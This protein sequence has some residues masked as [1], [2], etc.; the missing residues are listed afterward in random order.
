MALAASAEEP[1]TLKGHDGWVGGVALSA[2][3]K[4]LATASADNT[5]KL[6]DVDSGKATQVF[7]GHTDYVAA[8]AISPDGRAI[9][10]ASYDQ[11][12]RLWDAEAGTSRHVFKGHR[13]AV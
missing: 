9:A 10:T 5:A 11:T 8:V 4:V 7:K 12:A 2:D 6:W 1:R 13:G 3:G